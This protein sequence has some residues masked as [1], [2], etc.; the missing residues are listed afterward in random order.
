MGSEHS[1]LVSYSYIVANVHFYRGTKIGRE[2]TKIGRGGPILTARIDLARMILLAKVVRETSFGKISAKISPAGLISWGTDFGM[3]APCDH[4]Q[5]LQPINA[6]GRQL[7]NGSYYA[8]IV[9]IL[10]E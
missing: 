9:S 8:F 7:C 3:S 6:E 2:G 10:F 5:S 1:Q 4:D